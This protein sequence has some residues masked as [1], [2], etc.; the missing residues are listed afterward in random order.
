MTKG[1][2]IKQIKSAWTLPG[3]NVLRVR[4]AEFRSTLLLILPSRENPFLLDKILQDSGTLVYSPNWVQP[5]KSYYRG[6]IEI[7]NLKKSLGGRKRKNGG[8]KGKRKQKDTDEQMND[9]KV[10]E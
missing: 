5:A 10:N 1:I 9:R 2:D 3:T 6:D 4:I 8:K 7:K